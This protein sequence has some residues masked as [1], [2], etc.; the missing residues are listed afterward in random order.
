MKKAFTLVEMMVVVAVI[1]TLMAIVFRL[2]GTADNDTQRIE[3]INRLQRV[4]NCLSG[5]Y[6]AYGI[7]PPVR[8]HGSRDIYLAVNR[9]TQLQRPSGERNEDLWNWE[10][11]G[12]DAEQAAAAQVMA[13]CK[14]QPVAAKFPLDDQSGGK[15]GEGEMA[16]LV[17]RVAQ[18]LAER[19]ASGE[20][21]FR[22]FW[23]PP[24]VK[25]KLIAKFDD[26]QSQNVG[27]FEGKFGGIEW[28]DIQLFQF[29]LMSYLTPRYVVMI[30]CRGEDD[31][32][33]GELSKYDKIGLYDLADQWKVF[34]RIPANPITGE[35]YSTWAEFKK[36]MSP[37]AAE[38]IPSQSICARWIGNLEGICVGSAEKKVFGVTICTGQY[39]QLGIDNYGIEVYRPYGENNTRGQYVLDE[40]TVT[41]AF[42]PDGGRPRDLLYYCPHPYQSYV[43]WSA[44]PNG[45]TFPPWVDR[46]TLSAQANKCIAKWVED[47]I[48]KMS[49]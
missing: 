24:E 27:R 34:N 36:N 2:S 37:E 6:A 48:I 15:G 33:E 22:K 44:G 3:T 43:L 21:A 26:G 4:E 9:G 35:K 7:Y 8:L 19:A 38:K 46:R 17:S 16:S 39:S 10:N 12:E 28:G 45:R 13:A 1:V 11:I 41:D 14:A 47:D 20:E 31:G 42:S 18:G 30:G 23:D 49:H 32:S 29:G 40:L 5:Y 25:A